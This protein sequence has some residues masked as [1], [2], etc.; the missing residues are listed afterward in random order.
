M[1]TAIQGDAHVLSLEIGEELIESI[2]SYADREKISAASISAI[3]A[4]RSFELGYY[5]LDRK[6]YLRKKVD[7]IAELISCEGNLA[8]KKDK[9][10]VHLH[11]AAG[12]SDFSVIGGHLFSGIVAVSA[13]VVLRPMPN[14]MNRSF[15]NATG[16]YL[17]DLLPWKAF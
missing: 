8:L 5:V 9:P 6:E 13:E 17:L 10:F 1:R 2:L 11:V 16:L 7:G 3:G 4:I 14:T 12:L 15:S